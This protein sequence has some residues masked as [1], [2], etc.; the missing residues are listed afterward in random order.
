MSVSGGDSTHILV[1]GRVQGVGYRYFAAARAKMHG[2]VGYVS[3]LPDG[4]VEVVAVGPRVALAYFIG[5]LERGPS[6]GRVRSCQVAAIPQT[7]EFSE[8]SVRY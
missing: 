8:F 1:S 4:S 5:D 2:I 3:N 6:S 7:E